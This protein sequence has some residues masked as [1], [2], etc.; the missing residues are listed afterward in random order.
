MKIC[1]LN[2]CVSKIKWKDACSA[3][4]V[5][6][7]RFNVLVAIVIFGS[8]V[9]VSLRAVLSTMVPVLVHWKLSFKAT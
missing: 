8:S 3:L 9:E 2:T 7:L 4:Q 5:G 1:L 6:N